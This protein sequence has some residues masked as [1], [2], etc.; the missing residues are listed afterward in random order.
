MEFFHVSP[1]FK[2]KYLPHP[3]CKTPCNEIFMSALFSKTKISLT[4]TAKH[5]A[6]KNAE[7]PY[8]SQARARSKR[9]RSQ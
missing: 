6:M 3:N 8:A 1:F 7:L 2:H 4:L 9:H 5:P